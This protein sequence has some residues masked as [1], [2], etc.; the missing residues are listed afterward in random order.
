MSVF[1][2]PNSLDAATEDFSQMLELALS[3]VVRASDDFFGAGLAP[4]ERTRI[5]EQDVR[6]NQYERQIRK[7][8]V[9]H[10]SGARSADVPYGLLLMSLVKDVERLGD[11]AKN[12]VEVPELRRG[13]FPDDEYYRELLEIK[14]SVV[15]LAKEVGPVYSRGDT[16]RA[17]Q[18]TLQGRSVAKRCDQLVARVARSDYSANLAIALTLGARFFKRIEG[19]LLNVL[20]SVIMP[21]HKLDYFDEDVAPKIR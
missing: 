15:D 6:V 14:A 20:S 19:H 2:G 13:E 17:H 9:A 7:L 11:Y 10:L 1:R 8:V 12:L 4:A 21:L 16:E 5:Y 18:L 3:M